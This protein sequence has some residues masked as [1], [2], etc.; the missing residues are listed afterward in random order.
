MT[1]GVWGKPTQRG[2]S[3]RRAENHACFGGASAARGCMADGRLV[4]ARAEEN[5]AFLW[6]FRYAR[7]MKEKGRII[8]S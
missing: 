4:E 3:G 1:L 5:H 7:L 2:A 6:S 8:D